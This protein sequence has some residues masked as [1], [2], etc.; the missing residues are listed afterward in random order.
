MSR[1][2]PATSR[3]G[4]NALGQEAFGSKVPEALVTESPAASAA[5][6]TSA[7]TEAGAMTASEAEKAGTSAPPATEGE[8]GDRGTSEPQE[9]PPPWGILD[10]GMEAVNDEDR[11][12]YTG[13]SWEAEV[14]TDKEDLEKFRAAAQ[15]IGTVLLVRTFG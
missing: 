4:K 12:L 2:P 8:G 14:I 6:V 3:S 10:E 7:A 11:C 9:V 1:A 15:M 13:T 5:D